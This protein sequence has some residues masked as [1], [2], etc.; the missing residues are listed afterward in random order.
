L[1]LAE[2]EMVP[3]DSGHTMSVGVGVDVGNV[4][5]VV[6]VAGV[7]DAMMPVAE[8]VLVAG[9]EEL[10][11]YEEVILTAFV[12]L[13]GAGVKEALGT[14][15]VDARLSGHVNCVNITTA[16]EGTCA[17]IIAVAPLVFPNSRERAGKDKGGRKER[18][19]GGKPGEVAQALHYAAILHRQSSPAS[20]LTSVPK[21]PIWTSCDQMSGL[22]V[23]KSSSRTRQSSMQSLNGLRLTLRVQA[24]ATSQRV[25][26]IPIV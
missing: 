13:L 14:A 7:L 8:V 24:R 22:S 4:I 23:L 1:P 19:E 9:A 12:K 3:S 2:V 6:N 18:K 10:I 26:E 21:P 17:C 25:R 16:A 15:V 11:D 20:S 5:E